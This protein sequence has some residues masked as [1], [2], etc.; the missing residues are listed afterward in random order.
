VLATRPARPAKDLLHFIRP[1]RMHTATFPPD[2]LE[3]KSES[4][5]TTG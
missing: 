5:M 2:W 3:N 1:P 4:R